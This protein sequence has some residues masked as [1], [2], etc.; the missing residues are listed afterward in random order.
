[1]TTTTTILRAAGALAATVL[2]A[3][4]A[5]RPAGAQQP[6]GFEP[7]P[8]TAA[9]D[10][11]PAPPGE[12]RIVGGVE[13]P[14]GAW[15]SVAA[16]VQTGLSPYQGQFCAGTVVNPS[17]ILTAAH[18][19][20]DSRVDEPREVEVVTGTQNLS[21]G[22]TRFKVNEIF[23]HVGFD[24]STFD[25]DL[26]LVL[27]TSPTTVPLQPLV[28]QGTALAGG[29]AA[30]TAGWGNTTNVGTSYPAKLRQVD[31][32]ILTNGQC[33]PHF[34]S[35]EITANMVCAG[36]SPF[37]AKDSC[38]GDSGGPLV[39]DL[40]SGRVQVGI[41][42]WGY[43][44]AEGTPGVYTRLSRYTDIVHEA[45]ELGPYSSPESYVR[46]IWSDL[47][48]KKP[49]A[50]Q[51]LTALQALDG[52]PAAA[53]V[54][55]QIQGGSYQG[56]TGAITRLYKAFFLRD[57]DFAGLDHWAKQINGG[58]SLKSIAEF[59]ARSTEFRNRYGSLGN[60][61]YVDLVYQNVLGRAPDPAGRAYW[62]DQLASGKRSRGTMMIG[63]SE[64]NEYRNANRE[65]VDIIVTYY[66]LLRK[67]PTAANFATWSG[68]PLGELV[69]AILATPAYHVRH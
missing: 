68:R 66:G 31:V 11:T 47:Y 43:G 17:W 62:V 64:S 53:W 6:G 59:F 10:G 55:Q 37:F 15:P 25:N 57:P 1:M 30:F 22:G 5:P 35:G 50:A 61:A 8:A 41:V 67:V 52:Q 60:G 3:T 26:A 20:M 21:A 19:F 2:L 69:E 58:R 29:T 9:P 46:G 42:S 51:L 28:P 18:C 16:L 27:L 13:A 48:G 44:C 40:G 45:V 36:Q 14:A 33:A 34:S 56:R 63:F 54:T 7:T 32:P 65:R 23:F 38:Q 24:P 12:P 49:T 39:A 4:V